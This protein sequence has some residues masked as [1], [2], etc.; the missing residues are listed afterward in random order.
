MAGGGG[1]AGGQMLQGQWGQ[2]GPDG[3]GRRGWHGAGGQMLLE[4]VGM[5]GGWQGTGVQ[6]GA[7]RDQIRW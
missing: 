2:G 7:D 3:K 4:V 5:A 1:V 6:D